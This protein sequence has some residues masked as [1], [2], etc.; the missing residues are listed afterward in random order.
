MEPQ[1]LEVLHAGSQGR[2]SGKKNHAGKEKWRGPF[3]TRE[4]TA[5]LSHTE[6]VRFQL[7]A[8]FLQADAG[9]NKEIF[10]DCGVE[11]LIH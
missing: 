2:V 4:Y 9:E 3:G 10:M 1:R 11:S 8:D 5:S 7:R 6:R